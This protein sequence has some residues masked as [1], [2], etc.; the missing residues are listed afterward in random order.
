MHWCIAREGFGDGSVL[1]CEE[2]LVAFTHIV[3]PG[4][5]RAGGQSIMLQGAGTVCVHN[6]DTRMVQQCSAAHTLCRR[7]RGG[8]GAAAKKMIGQCQPADLVPAPSSPPRQ[9]PPSPTPNE[10]PPKTYIPPG[11]DK[12]GG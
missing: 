12:G 6:I 8:W 9:S 1:W 4:Q 10:P 11:V 7:G 2:H 5:G 3:P